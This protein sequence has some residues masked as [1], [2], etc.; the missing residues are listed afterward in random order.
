MIYKLEP[1]YLRKIT[2][3]F[4]FDNPQIDPKEHFENMKE[5]LIHY[6]GYG[7]ASN[8][9]GFN[10]S[11]FVMGDPKSPN[12]I[13]GYFNPRIVSYS[14]ETTENI[15]SCLSIQNFGCPVKRSVEIRLRATNYLGVTDTVVYKGLSS[16]IAQHEY[17][18]LL[19]KTFCSDV[20]RLKLNIAIKKCNK[21]FNVKYKISDFV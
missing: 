3:P 20:S 12:D 7:L 5:S 19:G 11:M 10:F 13:Q 1:K 21:R 14:E 8:Q 6:N 2:V 16:R 17:F 18:H 4:E 15:E 9:V